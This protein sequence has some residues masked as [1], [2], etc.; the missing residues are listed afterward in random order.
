METTDTQV[1][2]VSEKGSFV[3]DL[4]ILFTFIL[5]VNHNLN[6]SLMLPVFFI[7]LQQAA[8]PLSKMCTSLM[9]GRLEDHILIITS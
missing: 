1:D 4:V 7:G 3:H 5:K 8:L 2:Q 6:L 9:R